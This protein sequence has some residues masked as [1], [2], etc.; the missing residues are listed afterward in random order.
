MPPSSYADHPAAENVRYERSSTLT[1]PVGDRNLYATYAPY[2]NLAERRYRPDGQ[3]WEAPMSP[4]TEP[5]TTPTSSPETGDS[6]LSWHHPSAFTTWY[7]DDMSGLSRQT[8]MPV[9]YG[10]QQQNT[11][12][13]VTLMRGEGVV[14]LTQTADFRFS[15]VIPGR[16][17]AR[18]SSDVALISRTDNPDLSRP[19]SSEVGTGA[20]TTRVS[21][22]DTVSFPLSPWYQ[23]QWGAIPYRS[24][25]TNST[26]NV[27]EESRSSNISP[28]VFN[29]QYWSPEP[30]KMVAEAGSVE[31]MGYL[32]GT[33]A[34]PDFVTFHDVDIS[35]QFVHG[36]SSGGH[37]QEGGSAQTPQWQNV[38]Q[39]IGVASSAVDPYVGSV[40][41]STFSSLSGWAG[42][43]S[44]SERDYSPDNTIPAD[45]HRTSP[46]VDGWHDVNRSV[47]QPLG[48]GGGSR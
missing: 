5:P 15:G 17:H 41:I 47:L 24:E 34:E 6:A 37:F 45:H 44:S 9:G 29:N 20:A 42:D 31:G 33:T 23:R 12:P 2:P 28:D 8:T 14:P 4:G 16:R 25:P 11:P 35:P 1:A 40:H 32:H 3:R 38:P 43:T 46:V 21:R 39:R 13:H 19:A 30:G 7:P 27:S 48:L 18:T 10:Y 26:W 22:R 36:S